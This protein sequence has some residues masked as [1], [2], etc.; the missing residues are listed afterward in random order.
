MGAK[1][2]PLQWTPHCPPLP[3]AATRYRA[4]FC[5][6]LS[7]AAPLTH[8]RPAPPRRRA[9]VFLTL[10]HMLWCTALTYLASSARLVKLQR[11]SSRKQLY[12]IVLL[13]VIFLP[14]ILLNNVS[15][16]LIP[17]ERATQGAAVLCCAA[18]C[19]T[20]W[21]YDADRWGVGQAFKAC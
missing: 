11:L 13:S 5:P 2:P 19:T 15:L 12:K 10:C 16:R 20:V 18:H 9:P 3:P 1:P 7:A 4:R 21:C 8:S 6:T 14:T 17:S